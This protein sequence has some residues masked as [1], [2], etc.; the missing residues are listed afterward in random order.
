MDRCELLC[1]CMCVS[2]ESKWYIENRS[3]LPIP[4][5]LHGIL[6]TLPS[7]FLCIHPTHPGPGLYPIG[8]SPDLLSHSSPA[9]L[10]STSALDSF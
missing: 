4:G 8:N 5:Y 9:S 6:S 2:K 3:S 7:P 10:S 1:T